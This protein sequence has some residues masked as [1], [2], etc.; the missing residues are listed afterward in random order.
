VE[1][2]RREETEEM[3]E[4]TDAGEDWSDGAPAAEPLPAT[5]IVEMLE[6]A[7]TDQAGAVHPRKRAGWLKAVAVYLI[8]ALA[9]G[10]GGGFLVWE[11]TEPYRVAHN[12]LPLTAQSV[13]DL[14]PDDGWADSEANTIT[15]VDAALPSVVQIN[16]TGVKR[17]YNLS[18]PTQGVGSGF[19]YDREGHIITNNHVVEGN[20]NIE[21]IFPDGSRFT[22]RVVGTDRLSD[23]AIL[24]IDHL[25]AGVEPLPLADSE[26]VKVGQKAIAIG[27]PLGSDD[28]S[29]GLNRTPSVTQGIVS[30][31]DRVMPV[32]SESNPNVKDYQIED[33]LQTDAAI[34]PG[35]SGGPLL[36]SRGEVVGVNTAII[37]SAQGIGFAIPSNTVR[38]VADEL[39]NEGSVERPYLGVTFIDLSASEAVT[40]QKLEVPGGQGVMVTEVAA[41]SPAERAGLRGITQQRTNYGYVLLDLGD[42]I[43]AVNGVQISGETFSGELL[44]YKPGDT[45]TLTVYRESKTV[46]ISVTLGSR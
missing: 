44:K 4:G 46:E 33:L 37:A 17:A 23:L 34:N 6:A 38:T 35:N 31:T 2:E 7:A 45:I 18:V 8:V 26:Q 36:N 40:G 16:V 1:E 3:V 15:V 43:T 20:S 10:A 5:D 22:A 29:M 39:I 30:A 14:D 11:A 32:M 25:P 12:K 42:V 27:S 28:N 9:G 19:V 41:A 13:L 24:K 21:V